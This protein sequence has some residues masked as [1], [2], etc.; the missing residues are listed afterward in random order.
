MKK[1]L[2]T[3][4]Y[5]FAS[6]Q[7][8]FQAIRRHN[9]DIE[10]ETP[11]LDYGNPKDSHGQIFWTREPKQLIHLKYNIWHTCVQF[12]SVCFEN[13]HCLENKSLQPRAKRQISEMCFPHLIHPQGTIG[14]QAPTLT[15][16]LK[17]I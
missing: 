14:T 5:T 11:G 15:N 6:C 16:Q 3:S 7:A 12:S 17:L 2:I 9:L 10:I 8:H 4:F 1:S 13:C